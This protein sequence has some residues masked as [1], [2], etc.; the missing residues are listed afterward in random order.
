[1]A[2]LRF[3]LLIAGLVFLVVLA[4]WELRKPRQA[5]GNDT[6]RRPARSEPEFGSFAEPAARELRRPVAVPPRID[7]PEIELPDIDLLEAALPQMSA[8]EPAP[9][10]EPAIDSAILESPALASIAAESPTMPAASSADGASAATAAAAAPTLSA[11]APHSDIVVPSAPS[12]IVVDWPPDDVRQIVSL[13]IVAASGERLS[14]R[15]VRLAITA[16]G[17]VHGPYGIYHQPDRGGRALLSIANLSKPGVLDPQSMDFQRLTGINL[18]TV[19]PGPLAPAA[20]L[21]HLLETARDLSQ[22]LPGRVQDEHGQPLDE[23][24]LDDLRDRMQ[25]LSSSG[26]RAEPA[27]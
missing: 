6:L 3:I 11:A 19:L 16:C 1:M 15:A 26:A 2:E 5:S 20:A 22:R 9:P 4:A 24:R 7:L 12:A 18:F 8:R 25:T 13:R 27:A 21:D 23:A 10:M 17:F 14:G